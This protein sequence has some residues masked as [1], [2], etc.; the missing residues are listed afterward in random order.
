MPGLFNIPRSID[1]AACKLNKFGQPARHY[2]V[3]VESLA[4]EF[5]EQLEEKKSKKPK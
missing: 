2:L 3:D 5:M 1:S 4:E